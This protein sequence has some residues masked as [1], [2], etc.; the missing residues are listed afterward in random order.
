[1]YGGIGGVLLLL[2]IVS[3]I[4]IKSGAFEKVKNVRKSVFSKVLTVQKLTPSAKRGYEKMDDELGEDFSETEDDFMNKL[5]LTP[6]PLPK[7]Y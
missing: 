4:M 3:I 5:R 7:D 2:I 1:M 6:T